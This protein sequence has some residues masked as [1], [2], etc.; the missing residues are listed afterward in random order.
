MFVKQLIGKRQR[1]ACRIR[2]DRNEGSIIKSKI[3]YLIKGNY[4]G[5]LLRAIYQ[6]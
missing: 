2:Q 4:E 5:N 3:F 1:A 6:K